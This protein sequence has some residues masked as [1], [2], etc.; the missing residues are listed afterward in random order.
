MLHLIES[1]CELDRL[2][3][4]QRAVGLELRLCNAVDQTDFPSVLHTLVVPCRLR[5]INKRKFFFLGF[6]LLVYADVRANRLDSSAGG[7]R[8]LVQLRNRYI[9]NCF[10]SICIFEF[11]A[12][13]AANPVF[14]VA[15]S[16]CCR[17]YTVDMNERM[18]FY[19]DR[20]GIENSLAA[21]I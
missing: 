5:N 15:F 2:R 13:L 16:F 12:A 8:R 3:D 21:F 11:A 7:L 18:P 4:S 1:C 6:R 14:D 19:R 10:R 20:D 9:C 17:L